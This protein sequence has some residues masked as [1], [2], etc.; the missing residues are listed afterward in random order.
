MKATTITPKQFCEGIVTRHECQTPKG[1]HAYHAR[2]DGQR[3]IVEDENDNLVKVYFGATTDN[4]TVY[5]YLSDTGGF[6]GG[7]TYPHKAQPF[8]CLV[9]SINQGILYHSL[10]DLPKRSTFRVCPHCGER[11]N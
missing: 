3:V 1:R 7:W 2:L 10:D 4:R 11:L 6:I 9:E 8:Q 5:A